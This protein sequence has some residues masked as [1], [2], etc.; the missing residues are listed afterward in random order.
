MRESI[1]SALDRVDELYRP[2]HGGV[3]FGGFLRGDSRGGVGG[4]D[5]ITN[6][7]LSDDLSAFVRGELGYR[8]GDGGS[9]GLNYGLFGGVRWRF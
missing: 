8:Y 2:G 5:L 1:T 6:A 9:N 4:V 3:E 7:R